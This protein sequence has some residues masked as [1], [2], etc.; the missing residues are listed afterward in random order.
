MSEELKV[1]R[2]V[3]DTAPESHPTRNQQVG[4]SA[5]LSVPTGYLGRSG[6]VPNHRGLTGDREELGSRVR[7]VR[8]G[9]AP[10]LNRNTP[11]A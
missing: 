2:E 9:R 6:A 5:N 10:S 7:A 11:V 4:Q 8:L 1:G 3:G